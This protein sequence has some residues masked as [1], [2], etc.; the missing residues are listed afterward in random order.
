MPF[1][2]RNDAITPPPSTC[3]ETVKTRFIAFNTVVD[4]KI[5]L[6]EGM[7]E[8]EAGLALRAAQEQCDQFEALLSRTRPDSDVG[9]LNDSCGSLVQIDRITWEVLQ[10]GRFYS[11]QSAGYFDL[12]MG[13]VTRLWN[14]HEGVVPD[15]LAIDEALRHVDWRFL[16]LM[17]AGDACF[18]R[19]ADP[20]AAIDVG[21]YAKGYIADRLIEQLQKAG[22][23]NIYLSLGGNVAVRGTNERGRPWNIGV[24]NPFGPGVVGSVPLT[25]GSM[26]TSGVDER[27]FM[28]DGRRYHHILDCLTGCPAESDLAS[29]TVVSARS[30]DGDG[31]STALFCMGYEQ[32]AAFVEERP[33]LEAVFVL[34]DGTVRASSGAVFAPRDFVMT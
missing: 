30:S 32:A 15:V 6:D 25:A 19:L 20:A 4:V 17:E 10:L 29:V 14:F 2:L 8:D 13:A 21:G 28:R 26:V 18:G 24:R 9:R 34:A 3:S 27:F 31:F 12:T 23:R 33:E 16:E 11:S 22:A 7:G 1:D 5:V